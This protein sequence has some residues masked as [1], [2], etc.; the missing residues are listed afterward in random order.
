MS[1]AD[2]L[3]DALDDLLGQGIAES[4]LW[5]IGGGTWVPVTLVMAEI[6]DFLAQESADLENVRLINA[7]VSLSVVANPARG[8]VVNFPVTSSYAG[9][10]SVIGVEQRGPV[11]RVVRLRQSIREA[12]RDPAVQRVYR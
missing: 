7:L 6:P 8:D 3:D 10:W 12:A 11:H 5:S 4:A 2:D 1:L 9:S